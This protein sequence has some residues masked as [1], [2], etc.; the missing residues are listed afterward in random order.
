[1][2]MLL[3]LKYTEEPSE[4]VALMVTE[5]VLITAAHRTRHAAQ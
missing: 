1:M 2:E 4:Y 5:A 3:V